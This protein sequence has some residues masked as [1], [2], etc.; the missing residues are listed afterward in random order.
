MDAVAE[1][2]QL[3]LAVQPQEDILGLHVAVHDVLPVEVHQG[4]RDLGDALRGATLIEPA[5][6]LQGPVQ[7]P[8]GGIL[9]DQED[10]V[11]VVEP[12]VEAED[13]R[14]PQVAVDFDLA[15]D[16]DLGALPRDLV[17]P[18]YLQGA[19]VARLAVSGEVDAAELA[20]A[21][22]LA[23]LEQP[24]VQLQMCGSRSGDAVRDAG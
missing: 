10:A 5:L 2:G 20:L 4:Q 19:D 12:A 18:Q 15:P 23:D 3:Q 22:R 24:Q 13:A 11:R 7:L 9:E 6:A 16:V 1:V 17:L 21:E 8:A 14:V